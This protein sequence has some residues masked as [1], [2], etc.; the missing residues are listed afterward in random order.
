MYGV[1]YKAFDQSSKIYV[2]IKRIHSFHDGNGFPSTALR[3]ISI[4]KELNHP[5]IVKLYD[6][7]HENKSL[8]LV[9][10]CCDMDLKQLMEKSPH[11]RSN[12]KLIKYYLYQ[13]MIGIAYCHQRRLLHRDLKPQNLLV[14]KRNN[15]VKVADFGLART[16]DIPTKPYTHEVVSLWYRAPEIL[17]GLQSYGISVD[18]WFRMYL[19]N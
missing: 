15:C 6:N 19:P 4:L 9:F 10:E 16:F 17:L 18:I 12:K 13:I 14:D 3:E 2:A 11:L 7:F 1:V 8:Y 5:N